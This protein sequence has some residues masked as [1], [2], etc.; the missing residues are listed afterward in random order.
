MI[1][2]SVKLRI[3]G[4]STFPINILSKR[5]IKLRKIKFCKSFITFLVDGDSLTKCISV[6]DETNRK[7]DIIST[8]GVKYFIKHNSKRV[9]LILGSILALFMMI[10][11][12]STIL[13]IKITGN[14]LVKSEIIQNK[15]EETIKVPIFNVKIDNKK[16]EREIINID[17]IS[18]ASVEKRGTCINVVVL[19][20]LP[21]TNIEDI[22]IKKEALKSKYD[23][24]ITRLVVISGT[25]LVKEGQAVRKGQDLIVPYLIVDE[26]NKVFS[27]AGGEVYG[28]VWITES[29]TFYNQTLTYERTGKKYTRDDIKLFNWLKKDETVPYKNFEIEIE[30]IYLGGILPIVVT[31]YVYYETVQVYIDFD[32]DLN[33]EAIIKE[34]I[35]KLESELPPDAKKVRNWYVTKRLDKIVQLDIYYEIVTSII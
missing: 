25:P 31:R 10:V 24:V 29:K 32:F 8:N 1:K 14:E 20:E 6:L 15:I 11:Y 17:G 3:E 33:S 27:H 12:S 5:G 22:K 9:G 28:R 18:S 35:L 30:K 21:H 19:E 13:T 23:S 7:Y 34:M 16:L 4:K 26:N 2:N